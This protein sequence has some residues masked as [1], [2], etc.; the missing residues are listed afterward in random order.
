MSMYTVTRDLPTKKIYMYIEM[1]VT[2]TIWRKKLGYTYVQNQF[3]FLLKN[4][5]P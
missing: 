1:E 2:D 4:V 3:I 5:L